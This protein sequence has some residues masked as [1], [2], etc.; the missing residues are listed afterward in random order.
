MD[1]H[2]STPAAGADPSAR[3]VLHRVPVKTNLLALLSLP[4]GL[5]L[6]ACGSQVSDGGGFIQGSGGGGGEGNQGTTGTQGAGGSSA[7]PAVAMTR[8]QLDVLWDAYWAENGGGTSSSSSGGAPL[9]PNDLF[10]QISDLG[11]SCGSPTVEL[12]CGG[13]WSVSIGI[14][15]ALQQVGVYDLQDPLLSMYSSMS[16]TADASPGDPADCGWGGGSMG[17]GTLEILSITSDAIHF[18]LTMEPF[19]FDADPS[20]EYTAPRCP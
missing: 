19:V 15:P 6:A 20:G 8:A 17:P 14:P 9:D 3:V 10:V 18:Q 13:H 11:T 16:E 5:V 1:P 2:G 4:V 12:S 7:T